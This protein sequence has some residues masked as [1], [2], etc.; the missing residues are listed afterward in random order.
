MIPPQIDIGETGLYLDGWLYENFKADLNVLQIPL[1][2]VL[3]TDSAEYQEVCNLTTL[4][5]FNP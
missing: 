2:T 1:K 4:P 3:A 5:N